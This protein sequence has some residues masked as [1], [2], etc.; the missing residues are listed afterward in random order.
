MVIHGDGSID[1]VKAILDGAAIDYI[2]QGEEAVYVTGLAFN[3]WIFA[4]PERGMID[5][6]SYEPL[7]EGMD[8]VAALRCAN[9]FNQK[10]I[11]VQFSVSECGQRLNGRYLLSC[12][13][14][15]PAA[16]LLRAVRR[17]STVFQEAASDPRFSCRRTAA[18][19]FAA[20]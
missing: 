18:S 2:E 7:P 12:R 11:M 19:R 5:M 1:C 17:F 16:V 6:M 20:D 14:G 13:D 4:Q 9:A 15:L 3:F 10:F 8:E